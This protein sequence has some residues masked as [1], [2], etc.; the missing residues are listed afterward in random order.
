[1]NEEVI[2]AIIENPEATLKT[3]SKQQIV[4]ILK[5]ADKA[6]FSSSN[7]IL[8]DDIYDIVK[9]YLRKIDPKNPYLKS[10]GAV[11]E[12]NKEKLPYY[13]GS[14]DK[15]KDNEKEITKWKKTYDGE[16]IVSEKLD[17]ISCLLYYSNSDIKLYSRGDGVE[18]QNI[19]HIL[20]YLKL[21]L[22]KI[23]SGRH[24]QLGIRGELIISRANWQTISDV[25]A[26][27][28]NVVAGAIHSKSINSDVVSKIEFIAY[29]VMHPRLKPSASFDLIRELNLPLVRH[30]MVQTAEKLNNDLLSELLQTWRSSS[31]YE[32][33]GIVVYHNDVH[34]IMSGKNPKYAFA[35]KTIL[36][37]QQAEVI[38]T[39]VVW[40]VSKHRYLKPTVVFNEIV[41]GGVKIKQATGFNAAYI[42]KHK[43]G[44]GSRVMIVRSGDVIPHIISVL[45]VAANGKP[46]MP[47]DVSWK[48]NDTK[49]DIIIDGDEKNREQDIQAF[50]HFMKTL[51]VEGVRE[52][53]ITKLYDAGYDTLHKIINIS[54][55]KLKTIEGFQQ[56][57]ARNV[58]NALQAIQNVDYVKLMVA[59][60]VFGRGFGEKKLKIIVE[61]YPQITGK[62]KMNIS[63]SDLV[64]IEGIA[65]VSAKQFIEALPDFYRF[66]DELG[67]SV[68]IYEK[69]VAT[70][71]VASKFDEVFRNATVVFSG[72]RDKDLEN[73]I[74]S[75]GGRVATAI[76]GNTNIL[77]VKDIEDA[78]TKVQ[79]A[80]QLGIKIMTKSDVEH[81]R[82]IDI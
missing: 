73:L 57:S 76:S 31:A 44:P 74:Q 70:Q 64:Q 55:D 33:D 45:T 18:G 72:F 40:N 14:L 15:I 7:T 17:G 54:E 8:K 9:G 48:W 61:K 65:Q 75:V 81:I 71:V 34:K 26:N 42:E 67:I 11:I 58:Y 12:F 46:K 21:D 28:R 19:T 30:M 10:V 68:N 35:F 69:P 29:D 38:V 4:D 50:V 60:N 78:T 36:T 82:I 37:H 20:P 79:K 16:Y 3:L 52:G 24:N 22:S 49:I 32:I 25:G 2:K 39:D 53:V 5:A 13:L 1:M 80:K 47:S 59:S 51:D 23:R 77:I 41:L 27:A 6:F 43:I 66:V 62:R 56:K 63:I